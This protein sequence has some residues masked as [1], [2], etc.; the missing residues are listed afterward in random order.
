MIA[1]ACSH[2]IPRKR[3]ASCGRISLEHTKKQ[4]PE[5][6]EM[7]MVANRAHN[8]DGQLYMPVEQ[9]LALDESTDGKYEYLDG[10]VFMLRPPSSYYETADALDLAGGSTAHALLAVNMVNILSNALADSPC[11]VYNSDAKM[12]LIE[13]KRYLYPDVTVSCGEQEDTQY[14][15][16]PRVIVEVLSPTTEKRDR[17]TKFN[18]YKHLPSLQEYM[19][20]GSEY[21]AIE[22]YRREGAF[23]KQYS[24]QE[25][26]TIELAS[27]GVQFSFESVYRRVRIP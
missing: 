6:K 26:D 27:L 5:Q 4:I 14:I 24:Y 13:K 9:Y 12:K 17:G 22:V 10:F 18:A 1:S 3:S 25:G 21:K 8:G 7:H 16:N 11:F 23:W 20:I 2:L 19:L 15:T